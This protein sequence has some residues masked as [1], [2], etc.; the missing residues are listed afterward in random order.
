MNMMTNGRAS[1]PDRW[2]TRPR[3]ETYRSLDAL[4]EATRQMADNSNATVH[5][6]RQIEVVTD[7]SLSRPES[8]TAL[9]LRL[10]DGSL[11]QATHWSFGQM[12]SLIGAPSGFM[13][14]LPAPVAAVPLQ[15]KLTSYNGELVKT[16]VDQRDSTLRAL[17]SPTYG[18]VNDHKLVDAIRQIAGNGVGDTNWIAAQ[19]ANGKEPGFYASDR[20]MFVFLVDRERPIELRQHSNNRLVRL[21]RGFFAWNSEVGSRSLGIKTF[22]YCQHCDNR[23]IAGV[24]QVE[25]IVIRHTKGAPER[26]LQA[27]KPA[28]LEYATGSTTGIVDAIQ[29]AMNTRVASDHDEAVDFLN[30]K[31]SFSRSAAKAAL[32]Q[33]MVEEG[34]PARSAWEMAQ[35]ITAFA[36]SIPHQDDR[37]DIEKQ[38][39]KLLSGR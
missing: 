35:A 1:I 20:D 18:R 9:A 16:Y 21:F 27:A 12:C 6:V 11:T 38:A 28:L 23:L 39:T 3:D 5:D 2:I 14:D 17:T 13:R 29:R 25:Q 8:L 10:P 33:H 37:I 15:Y 19:M 36:R 34:I 22:L 26:F 31:T 24:D 4:Y 7:S 30:S 32:E